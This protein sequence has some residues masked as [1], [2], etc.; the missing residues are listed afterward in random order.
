MGRT[1]IAVG[2]LVLAGALTACGSG[3]SSASG[4]GAGSPTDAS[5]EAFCK[6]FDELAGD[7]SPEEAADKLSEV[8][9]PGD[10]SSDAQHGFQVLVDHL[11]QLPDDAKE[12]D[13]TEMARGLS[14]SDRADVTAFISY[15]AQTCQHI[16]TDLPS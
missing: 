16:P 13:I 9:T 12:S 6:T 11:R 5:E 15:Y 4:D 2:T 14:G 10:I 7:V 8:G 3:S 1:G